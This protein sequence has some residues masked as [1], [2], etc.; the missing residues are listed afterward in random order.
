MPMSLNSLNLNLLKVFS[1]VY[2][3]KSMTTAARELHLTQSG[4][5]QHIKSLEAAAGVAL[6]DRIGKTL[7][8][9]PDGRTLFE[10]CT[11]NL[12][13][14]DHTFSTLKSQL[15]TFSGSV[16]IGMPV[17]FGTN[18]LLP[19]LSRFAE[20]YP[21]VNFQVK[22]DFAS[23]MNGLLLEGSLDFAFVDDFRMDRKIVTEK[24]YDEV[25]ELCCS[26]AYF[27]KIQ[28]S[29]KEMREKTFFE[30]LDYIE[31]QPDAPILRNWF[32]HHLKLL[33]PKIRMRASVMDVQAVAKLILSGLGAGVIPVHLVDK[34]E[35]EGQVLHRFKA[36]GKPLKNSISIAQLEERSFS[37]QASALKT[38]FKREL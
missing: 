26:Q 3:A 28:K 9:T 23:I 21:A 5:S 25:L 7:V 2:R 29:E 13:E 27:K 8:A 6:F 16:S 12:A 10:A 32:N 20:K 34:L 38:W 24:V 11:K 14:L 4:V 36:S 17:E 18:V 31:Y 37:R 15:G 33:S 22:L 1:A 19:V 35:A 30:S